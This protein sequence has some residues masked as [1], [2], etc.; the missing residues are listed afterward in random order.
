[1]KLKV[2]RQFLRTKQ[3]LKDAILETW[4]SIKKT[5]IQ[6]CIDDLPKIPKKMEKIL[7]NEGNLL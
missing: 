2:E 6:K 4:D 5:D 1:M 7:N 3:Q